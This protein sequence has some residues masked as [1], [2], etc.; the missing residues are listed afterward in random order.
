MTQWIR[1]WGLGLFIAILLLAWLATNPLIKRGIE[2]AGTQAVGAKVELDS[3]TWRWG[4]PSLTLERLQVTSPQEPMTNM[5]E[6]GR[7]EFALDGWAL[8]RRQFVAENLA[9]E[10]LAF[11]T[12]REQSG[13][14]ERRIFA[15]DRSGEDEAE[16]FDITRL[17]P[18]LADMPDP[19]ELAT[20]GRDNI[21]A[22]LDEIETRAGAIETGWDEH[23]QRLPGSDT[24]SGYRERWR[25]LERRDPLR[26]AAGV[27]ELTRDIDRDLDTIRTLDDRLQNDRQTL[28]ELNR[29]ARALP[30]QESRRLVSGM[31][32]D[33]GLEGF[34]RALL[35]EELTGQVDQGLAVY[36]F[37]ST[38][39]AGR[40]RT[41]EPARPPRGEGEYIRFP[42]E[43]PLPRFLI[44]RAA[45]NGVMEIA[46]Q[47]IRFSGQIRDITHQPAVWGRPMTLAIEGGNEAGAELNV[48]GRFDHRDS[49]SRDELDF[50]LTG[51]A[52]NDL[53]LSGS[54]R[55][56]IVLEES[57]ADITGK[58]V[59]TERRLDSSVNTRFERARFSAGSEDASS[60]VRRVASAIEGVSA[61]RLDLGLGGT[62][63]SPQIS[64]NSDLDRIIMRALGDEVRRELA[65][66]REEVEQR[67]RAEVESELDAIA[68]Y[69]AQLEDFQRQIDERR[70]ELR[71]IRP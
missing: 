24:V 60:T 2:F 59:V 70:R 9:V 53:T 64:V 29:Q 68:A 13:A 46:D 35:G 23:I 62:L 25:E 52:I 55:L 47:P 31:G 49:P 12:P 3:V 7:M 39:L 41:E 65:Q 43:Q 28:R 50:T 5:F 38:H 14:I 1:W 42:E 69:E 11:H 22:E 63:R 54:S 20:E 45:V 27:R 34:T 17:L 71:D 26:R 33:D 66:T 51:L 48:N 21:K 15:R 67:L 44:K 19:G 37:A 57:R 40:K 36:E 61:F 32:L 58:L 6:A 8:L 16:D 30:G 18:G 56:P 10:D 4:G